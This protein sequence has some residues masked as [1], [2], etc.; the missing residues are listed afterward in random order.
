MLLQVNNDRSRDYTIPSTPVVNTQPSILGQ[1]PVPIMGPPPPPPP[2]QYIGSQYTPISGQAMMPQS[3][4]GWGTVPPP[5]AHSIPPHMV[6]NIYM[7][8]P[9]GNMP[10]QMVPG[11]QFPNYGS[12]RTQ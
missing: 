1:Q 2:Q 3:Q 4:A 9:P 12:D 6:N 8:P 5:A 11:S 7:P 10:P